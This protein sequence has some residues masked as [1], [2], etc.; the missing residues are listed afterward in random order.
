[1]KELKRYLKMKGLTAREFS[2]LSGIDHSQI[3]RYL[4]GLIRPSLEN[5]YRI[6]KATKGDVRMEDWV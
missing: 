1:M 3:S 2:I 4:R 5:A 6:Q